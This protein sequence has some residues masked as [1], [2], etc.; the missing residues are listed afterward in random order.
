MTFVEINTNEERNVLN[1]VNNL[2]HFIAKGKKTCQTNWDF[3][4]NATPFKECVCEYFIELNTANFNILSNFL[5]WVLL[6]K[7]QI[8]KVMN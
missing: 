4:V 2:L 7:M 6:K 1:F 8:N 3:R 5:N